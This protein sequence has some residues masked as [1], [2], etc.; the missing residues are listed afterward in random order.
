MTS[1]AAWSICINRSRLCYQIR[2]WNAFYFN[3]FEKNDNNLYAVYFICNLLIVF[4]LCHKLRWSYSMLQMQNRLSYQQIISTWLSL[5]LVRTRGTKRCRS[6]FSYWLK[7]HQM[8]LTR[9]ERNRTE[10]ERIRNQFWYDVVKAICSG[11]NNILQLRSMWKKISQSHSV[12]LKSL[13]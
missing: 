3:S 2:L 11:S 1:T 7:R 6:I 5:L 12:S 4:R 13:R 9:V 10:S 8:L